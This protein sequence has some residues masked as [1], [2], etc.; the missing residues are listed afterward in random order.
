MPVSD[1]EAGR[2]EA[3]NNQEPRLCQ[4]FF[5]AANNGALGWIVEEKFVSSPI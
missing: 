1:P 4:G 5:A 3:R 2:W